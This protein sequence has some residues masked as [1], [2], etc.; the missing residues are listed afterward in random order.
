MKSPTSEDEKGVAN[1]NLQQFTTLFNVEMKRMPIIIKLLD[2]TGLA[3]MTWT[4]RNAWFTKVA[5]TGLTSFDEVDS[6]AIET[7]EVTHEG[8]TIS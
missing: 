2:E 1:L 7:L 3:T 8:F 6:V 4:L 5:G